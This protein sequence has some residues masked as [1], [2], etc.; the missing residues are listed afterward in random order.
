MVD[1]IGS[2]IVDGTEV[3]LVLIEMAFCLYLEEQWEKGGGRAL[4][5]K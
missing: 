5:C 3:A 2:Q 1:R 4:P